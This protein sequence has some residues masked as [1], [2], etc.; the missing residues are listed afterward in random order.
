MKRSKSSRRWLDEH[1]NDFYV[2]KAQQ[3][4]Y[5]SRAAYK[6]KEVDEK[7]KLLRPGMVVVDLGASPGG[8]TQYVSETLDQSGTIIALD[9]LPMDALAGVVF[10]QGDF[11]EDKVLEQLR[12]VIP[13]QGVDLLLSDMAPNM[14]G[15]RAVDMPRAMYLA[16]LTFDLSTQILK[17]GASLFLKVFH[18][19]GFDD[20]VKLARAQFDKVVIRKPQASRSR[21]RETSLL[22]KGYKL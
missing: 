2:K 5:R 19:S 15:N 11:S 9:C 12:Q 8:W 1:F 7:E 16:E 20:L 22:A 3:D 18:G 13:S 17:P 21:S 6:L 14:S 10:I 4:G